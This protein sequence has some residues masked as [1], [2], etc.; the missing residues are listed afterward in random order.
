[1]S[2]PILVRSIE[3]TDFEAWLPLWQGYNAFYGRKDETALAADITRSTWQRFFE[4]GEPV[5]ALVALR[6]DRLVGLAH[7]LHHR[8][9]TR[10]EPVCY[11]QDLLTLPSERGRGVG[12][13][14]IQGV[15]DHARSADIRRVYWQ[16]QA[17]NAAGRQLYDKVAAHQGF[18]VY[19][20]DV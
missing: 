17:T 9:T 14:L 12:R 8:S 5:Y 3:P 6:A 1:M 20:H 16:T 18:I 19:T 13:A 2:D 11:L 15:Y 4:P 10:I 7:F